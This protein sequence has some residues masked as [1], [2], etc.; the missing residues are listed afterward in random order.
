[1]PS[2]V[3]ITLPFPPS[4]NGYWRCYMGRA[5]LSKPGR[6]YRKKTLAAVAEQG[7]PQFGDARVEVTMILHAPD[8]RR[9]DI[10]NYSK[11]VLDGLTHAGVWS[12][13]E[14]IDDLHI[15]R[16]E[17]RKGEGAAV[18]TITSSGKGE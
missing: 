14:Q 1:M 10:D 2:A 12:D 6:E 8:S 18:V 17:I 13:D 16:G 5:I 4:V 3:T 7:S 15:K 11:G 9:R